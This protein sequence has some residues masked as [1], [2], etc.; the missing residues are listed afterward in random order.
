MN[1]SFKGFLQLIFFKLA[2]PTGRPLER[3]K[4]RIL[5]K[6]IRVITS[7]QRLLLCSYARKIACTWWVYWICIVL[8]YNSLRFL[9]CQI[10]NYIIFLS[11]LVLSLIATRRWWTR[12]MVTTVVKNARRSSQITNGG[13][14]FRCVSLMPLKHQFFSLLSLVL[15]DFWL[16]I[17]LCRPIWLT[18]LTTSGWP[19]SKRVLKCFLGSQL[20]NLANSDKMCVFILA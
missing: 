1:S 6:E 19:A 15:S 2:T 10:L 5:D 14:F 13:W 11:R 8:Y 7:Q 9:N 18:I 3:S 12:Q 4:C 20:M 17:A 16:F